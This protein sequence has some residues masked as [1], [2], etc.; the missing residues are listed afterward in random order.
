MIDI[1]IKEVEAGIIQILRS[2]LS[3]AEI[4]DQIDDKTSLL[5]DIG[6]DSVQIIEFVV[7]LEQKFGV[8]IVDE[9]LSAELFDEFGRLVRYIH[10]KMKERVHSS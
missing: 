5:R 9:E 7:A 2:E 4:D 3:S 1:D 8:P 6:L 10:T